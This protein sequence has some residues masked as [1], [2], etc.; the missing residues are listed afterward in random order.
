MTDS[1]QGILYFAFTKMVDYTD[2]DLVLSAFIGFCSD[3]LVRLCPWSSERPTFALKFL[4]DN[5]LHEACMSYFL[6]PSADHLPFLLSDSATYLQRYCGMWQDDLLND[7]NLCAKVTAKLSRQFKNASK[8]DWHS[9]DALRS[10]LAVLGALPRCLHLPGFRG[11]RDVVSPLF[12]VPADTYSPYVIDQLR[13]IFCEKIDSRAPTRATIAEG[14]ADR[15][16]KRLLY[17]Y[18]YERNPGLWS[19]LVKVADTV[20]L[21]HP[22]LAAVNFM[23][24]F[25]VADWEVVDK[26]VMPSLPSEEE[27]SRMRGGVAAPTSGIDA[28]IF[29]RGVAEIVL[30]YVLAPP[31]SFSLS[32]QARASSI[33]GK[34]PT[35]TIAKA[36]SELT[37]CILDLLQKKE[38]TPEME[39]MLEV[40]TRQVER[41]SRT[42]VTQGPGESIATMRR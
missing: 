2:D 36:K 10:D 20:A 23:I 32:V 4:K 17:L 28:L 11:Y 24:A 12:D 39:Q 22:A 7:D 41:N 33:H 35:Q 9:S 1:T 29:E 6:N 5:H 34:D 27:L 8:A 40:F 14:K 13:L 42:E 3:Y 21:T 38:R 19:H 37:S 16:I 26:H 30:P 18:Y 15:M 25:A 31:R